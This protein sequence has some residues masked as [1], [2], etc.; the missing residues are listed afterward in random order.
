MHKF[1]LGVGSE[2]ADTRGPEPVSLSF[3][4][5]YLGRSR[6]AAVCFVLLLLPPPFS[7]PLLR[8]TDRPDQTHA[9]EEEDILLRHAGT[10]LPCSSLS[11]VP[12]SRV[13]LVFVG[14]LLC[15]T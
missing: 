1:S 5:Q 4:V 14:P 6:A 11:V 2:A 3:C 7:S 8:R 12:Q 10:S 9:S 13:S 15:L